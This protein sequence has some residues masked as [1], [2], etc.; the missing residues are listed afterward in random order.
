MYECVCSFACCCVD[1][2]LNTNVVGVEVLRRLTVSLSFRKAITGPEE[3]CVC[4]CVCTGRRTGTG[5]LV[6]VNAHSVVFV[7]DQAKEKGR[8]R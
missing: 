4:V 2:W 8:R 1:E 5:R 3:D 6:C 7:C